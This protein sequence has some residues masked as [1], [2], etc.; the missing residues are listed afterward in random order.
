MFKAALFLSLAAAYVFASFSL[1]SL[2]GAFIQYHE[3]A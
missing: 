3:N 1:S 2:L